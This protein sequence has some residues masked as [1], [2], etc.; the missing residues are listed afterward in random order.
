M[1]TTIYSPLN[2]LHPSLKIASRLDMIDRFSVVTLV[3]FFV[4]TLFVIQPLSFHIQLPFVGR[5]RVTIGLTT[6]PIIAISIL[7]ASQCIGSTQIRNGIV[8][9]G[10]YVQ[11]HSS[12]STIT[13][14]YRRH[15]T[16]QHSHPFHLTGLHSDYIGR[17]RDPASSGV[18]GEQS[19]WI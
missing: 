4:S 3:F 14:S 5:R 7:W 8:G 16:L 13:L 18:L 11:L 15:Q 2:L 17:H 6:A 19:G 12:Y 9:T 10:Q 1:S